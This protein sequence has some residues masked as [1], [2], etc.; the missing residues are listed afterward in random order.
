MKKKKK[1]KR[2]MKKNSRRIVLDMSS[3]NIRC[4]VGRFDDVNFSVENTFSIPLEDGLYE[5]GIILDHAKLKTH[6]RNHLD[7]YRVR[8]KN[9]VVITESTEILKRDITIPKVEDH[10]IND[11][12]RFE[13]GQYLPIDL[14]DYILQHHRVADI[15]DEDV[16]KV[17]ETIVAMPKTIAKA[18]YDLVTSA[19]LK[20]VALDLKGH[21]MM[22]LADHCD[23]Y[24]KDT[25]YAYIDMDFEKI[26][27][28]IANNGR[29]MLNRILK[30]GLG[31]VNNIL[32]DHGIVNENE[33][34]H[35]YNL[36]LSYGVDDLIRGFVNSELPNG[37]VLYNDLRDFFRQTAAEIERIFKFYLSRSLYN[38]VDQVIVYGSAAGIN[39]IEQFIESHLTIPTVRYIPY[40]NS[41]KQATIEDKD[42]PLYIN[43]LGGMVKY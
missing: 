26:E 33:I 28:N 25:S 43:A 23:D 21:S 5:N 6:L 37:E 15:D 18:H 2:I 22:R 32:R 38:A 11:L 16:S 24:S 10:D 31:D 12:V 30:F 14:E 34:K 17:I 40:G 29:I 19:G 4:A 1:K 42:F 8:A 35:V 3:K 9:C 7:L 13:V 27:I 41:F 39:Q 20:P 36:L